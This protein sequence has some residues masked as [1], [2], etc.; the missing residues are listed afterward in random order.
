MK[1]LKETFFERLRSRMGPASAIKAIAQVQRAARQEQIDYMTI[2][3]AS[4]IV[5][6]YKLQARCAIRSYRRWTDRQATSSILEDLVAE[7]GRLLRDTARSQTSL[8]QKAKRDYLELVDLALK[9]YG[10]AD[11]QPANRR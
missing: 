6:H 8:Y 2:K 4:E 1:I 11:F 5:Q 7:K 3:E 10:D 9:P